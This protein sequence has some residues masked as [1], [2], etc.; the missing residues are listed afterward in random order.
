MMNKYSPA[1]FLRVAALLAASLLFAV[2]CAIWLWS[3]IA[4]DG[5]AQADLDVLQEASARLAQ[6]SLQL[7]PSKL[8]TLGNTPGLAAAALQSNLL[9]QASAAGLET[10][11]VETLPG[12]DSMPPAA[13]LRLE[14]RG[15]EEAFASFLLGMEAGE[16]L[17]FVQELRLEA[18]AAA[19]APGLL[20][21]L[22]VSAPVG[23][24]QP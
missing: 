17:V 18:Q 23:G 2:L 7:D 3:A 12:D 10:V 19:D 6:E 11:N 20:A 22:V 9:A 5:R 4:R 1:A 24:L 8:L 21:T 14:L 15:S 13:L 16:P